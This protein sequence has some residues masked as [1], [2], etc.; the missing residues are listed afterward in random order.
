MTYKTCEKESNQIRRQLE[1][2]Q[3]YL[4]EEQTSEIQ[5]KKDQKHSL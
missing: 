1:Q 5:K 4:G 3:A 2:L